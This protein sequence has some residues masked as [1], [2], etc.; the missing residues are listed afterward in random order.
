VE[1]HDHHCGF[2]GV[3]IGK[4]NIASFVSFLFWTSVHGCLT[5]L[6]ATAFMT[7]NALD[8]RLY[9]QEKKEFLMMVA[10][11]MVGMHGFFFCFTLAGLA[12]YTNGLAME[13]KTSNENLRNKW[14]AK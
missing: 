6:Y 11:L 1:V 5:G 9:S 13:N 4:R 14:N 8:G 12:R 2:V 10:N 3:C 7:K